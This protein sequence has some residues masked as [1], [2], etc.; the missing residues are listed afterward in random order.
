MAEF[1]TLPPLIRRNK[2]YVTPYNSISCDKILFLMAHH[3]QQK[4]KPAAYKNFFPK[5]TPG[6][7][8]HKKYK[9]HIRTSFTP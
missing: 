6:E 9:N 7:N 5:I 8:N 2:N 1:F 3:G 4:R